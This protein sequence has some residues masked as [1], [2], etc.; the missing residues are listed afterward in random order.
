MQS[1]NYWAQ[2][3]QLVVA[4]QDHQRLHGA[5]HVGD[6]SGL[7][8]FIDILEMLPPLTSD[9]SPVESDLRLLQ[10]LDEGLRMGFASHQ[11]LLDSI[12]A[13]MNALGD[14]IAPMAP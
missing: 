8:I 5:G 7:E 6:D 14:R 2:A 10:F 12:G 1:A 11:I 9:A 4:W 13:T 3:A